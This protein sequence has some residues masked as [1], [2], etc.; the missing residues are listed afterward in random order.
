M[1]ALL[2][3]I[4][5][6]LSFNLEL[7]ANYGHPVV[8]FASQ[9]EIERLHR[10]GVSLE[11]F[12]SYTVNNPTASGGR[13][14]IV[15]VYSEESRTITLEDTWTGVSPAELS[16]LVHEMVHHLQAVSELKYECAGARERLAYEA[17]EKSL[18]HF[19]R[20]IEAEFGIDQFTLKVL[21]TCE[22]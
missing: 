2:T 12:S 10:T 8:E 6:W 22:Y 5:T 13:S 9:Q 4:V 14:D 15:A 11:K 16:V 1:D 21:T 20:S 3:A 18:G 7:P 19:G 17:Q